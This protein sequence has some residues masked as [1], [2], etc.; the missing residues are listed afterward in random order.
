MDLNGVP[1]EN[2]PTG[3]I[4]NFID[5]PSRGYEVIIAVAICL[6]FMI[7]SVV[8]RLYTRIFISRSLGWDDCESDW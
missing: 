7:P 6:T 3:V 2:P 8:I 5:P 1:V 4:P